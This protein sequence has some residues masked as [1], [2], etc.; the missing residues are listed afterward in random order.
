MKSHPAR[1]YGNEDSPTVWSQI[2]LGIS[3]FFYPCGTS[4]F[5]DPDAVDP[6]DEATEMHLKAYSSLI[7]G[8]LHQSAMIYEQ[9]VDKNPYDLLALRTAHDLFVQLGKVQQSHSIVTQVLPLLVNVR[10]P[11]FTR[12][13]V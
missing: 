2:L 6:I 13:R 3:D 1:L 8:Q 9:L 5:V 11:N 4:A 12:F 7:G 10:N